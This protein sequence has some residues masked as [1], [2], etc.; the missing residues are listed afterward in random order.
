MQPCLVI[1]KAHPDLIVGNRDR[2]RI[3]NVSEVRQSFVLVIE[4]GETMTA[5]G[6]IVKLPYDY[7]TVVDTGG[8]AESPARIVDRLKRIIT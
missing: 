2:R 3:E 4:I 8:Y 6:G 5:T 1:R 7:A